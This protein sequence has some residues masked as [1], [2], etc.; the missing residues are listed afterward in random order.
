MIAELL[1][2]LANR[3]AG[4]A[5]AVA[6]P[7]HQKLRQASLGRRRAVPI[8]TQWA[9]A[10]RDDARPLAWL[11]APSVGE[12]LM[13]QA[14]ITE[15]RM[16]E[17][18]AQLVFT[19]FSPSAERMAARVGADVAAY[20]PWDTRGSAARLVALLQPAVLAFVRTEIWPAHLRAT[21]R[22]GGRTALI[23][24]VISDGS[25]RL[26]GPARR[27][28]SPSYAM[29]DAVGAVGEED[30]HRLPRLGV[31]A[32][33]ITVTGDARFDQVHARVA[34]IDRSSPLLTRFGST[35]TVVAG[36]T[37]P[38]DEAIL[39]PACRSLL[40]HGNV[41]I[42]I[43]PHEPTESHLTGLE[44]GCTRNALRSVRLAKFEAGND[45]PVILV[46]RVGVLADLYAVA[47]AAYV[48]GGFGRAGLHSV[49][50]PA[51]LGV[52]VAFGGAVGNAREALELAGVGGGVVVRDAAELAATLRTWLG[53][54]DA[55]TRAADAAAGFVA[56][57]LGGAR[58]N[59][60]LIVRLLA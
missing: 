59:A 31:E 7:F 32:A 24:A 56:A 44:R 46:D 38:A 21:A 11:H 13:A 22:L 42:V 12:A 29:L 40:A 52:P 34:A 28:L 10:E 37:W 54:A 35:P 43:A 23:N 39:L 25:S 9:R 19:H 48:G 47:L 55:R 45:A 1:Y 36:S 53:D 3:A 2:E 4:P 50:E 51:A 58:R 26:R 17:P 18:R 27:L 60:E 49:V 5:L 8:L 20:L 6:A 30:A 41:R 57:R 16:A 14:I 33:R 15:L